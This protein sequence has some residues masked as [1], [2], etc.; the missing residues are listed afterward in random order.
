MLQEHTMH[1]RLATVYP[2]SDLGLCLLRPRLLLA[3][4]VAGD[5]D[6]MGGLKGRN[7]RN[8]MLPV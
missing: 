2:F 1:V 7:M 5:F 8:L 3:A 6:S 4:K